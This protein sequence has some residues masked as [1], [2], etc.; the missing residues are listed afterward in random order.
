MA[1]QRKL[2]LSKNLLEMKFMKKSK[3]KVETEK[4]ASEGKIGF[5]NDLTESMK[6]SGSRYI[7]EPSFAPLED[8]IFGR[9]SFR[10]QNPEIEKIMKDIETAK[11]EKLIQ[12]KEEAGTVSAEE[13]ANRYS[14]LIGTI[15]KKFANKRQRES[16]PAEN[17]EAKRR[18][19]RKPDF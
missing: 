9:M 8:L 13:M 10:G 6:K 4:Y 19:F 12:E 11:Q 15:G 2:K 14:T 7:I 16:S 3:E 1:N 5:D 18:K 17:S